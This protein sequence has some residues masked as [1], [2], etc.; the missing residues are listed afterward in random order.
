MVEV[1]DRPPYPAKFLGM[2]CV[3]GTWY[4]VWCYNDKRILTRWP[5]NDPGHSGR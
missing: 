1:F 5:G 4:Q 3:Q 2:E